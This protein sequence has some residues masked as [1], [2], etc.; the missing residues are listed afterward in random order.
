MRR[1][2]EQGTTASK[3]TT[4]GTA[5]LEWFIRRMRVVRH[6]QEKLLAAVRNLVD[7]DVVSWAMLVDGGSIDLDEASGHQRAIT[8]SIQREPLH[9]GGP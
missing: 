4:M 7:K 6:G 1:F 5:D 8:V 9:H 3:C 2:Q